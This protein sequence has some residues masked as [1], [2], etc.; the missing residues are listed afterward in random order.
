VLYNDFDFE[1]VRHTFYKSSL[2]AGKLAN[3][4]AHQR[5]TLE[6]QKI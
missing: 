6:I 1:E 3:A 4:K 5:T 2:N